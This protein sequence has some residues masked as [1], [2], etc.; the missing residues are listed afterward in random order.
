[1]VLYLEE[2]GTVFIWLEFGNKKRKQVASI[3]GIR[4]LLFPSLAGISLFLLFVP[5]ALLYTLHSFFFWI[6]F[7]LRAFPMGWC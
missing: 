4:F 6:A 7:W 3:G 5:P 2:H 1:M